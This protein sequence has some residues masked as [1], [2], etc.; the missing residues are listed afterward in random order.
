MAIARYE[1]RATAAHSALHQI[2][3]SEMSR[4]LNRRNINLMNLLDRN[5]ICLFR[6]DES[7]FWSL[8]KG[9]TEPDD[10]NSSLEITMAF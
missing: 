9:M 1:M 7:A 5:E 10:S 4:Q 6:S 8:R 3:S 2:M